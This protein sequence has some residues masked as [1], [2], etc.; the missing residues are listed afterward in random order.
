MLDNLFQGVFDSNYVNVI[1]VDKFLLCVAVSRKAASVWRQ[2]SWN[3]CSAGKVQ[4]G[5]VWARRRERPCPRRVRPF[6][7]PAE[8]LSEKRRDDAKKRLKL[9]DLG[10]HFPTRAIPHP[11]LRR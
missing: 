3:E 9:G 1:S 6:L 7:G 11:R 4:V 5:Q 2:L 10:S 8:V